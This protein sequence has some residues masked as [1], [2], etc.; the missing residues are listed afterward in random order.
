MF[1]TNWC[2]DLDFL[3]LQ[4]HP[5]GE[6]KQFFCP[7]LS[8]GSSFRHVSSWKTTSC[9]PCCCIPVWTPMQKINP[10]RSS[11]FLSK[12][13]FMSWHFWIWV[14]CQTGIVLSTCPRLIVV[15]YPV[16]VNRGIFSL[17]Q[18]AVFQTKSERVR[19][20]TTAELATR[21]LLGHTAKEVA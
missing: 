14:L 12:T 1:R 6:T 2:F 3:R 5:G 15:F 18:S 9:V 16:L 13:V 17:A 4:G 7:A 11:V 8:E 20:E 10:L 19:L 21:Y